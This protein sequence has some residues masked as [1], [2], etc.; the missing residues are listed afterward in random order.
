MKAVTFTA[1]GTGWWVACDVPAL[2]PGAEALVRAA[3]ARLS[4]FDSASSLSRLNA[5]R[6][7]TDPLLAA[8]V[9]AA[10]DL[11]DRTGGAFDPT[12]GARLAALGYDRDLA[13]IGRPAPAAA[14]HP[15]DLGVRVV[16]DEVRLDGAGALDL[17]GVAKGFTVDR[18]VAALRGWGARRVLVDGGGDLRGAGGAWPI[19]VGDGLAVWTDA[20]AVATSSTR[21]RRWRDQGDRPLH[22]VLD[23]RTGWPAA[24]PVRTAVVVA[25]DAATADGLATALLVDA[26]GVV[27]RLAGL[28]AHALL[29]VGAGG[30][31]MTPGA[32]VAATTAAELVAVAVAAGEA[33]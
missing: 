6:R 15:G 5:A 4:R 20:G 26:P 27:P 19:G 25:P 10:L 22:H 8:V 2:L 24:S 30:W 13:D 33:P 29:D 23:P 11:R 3:E 21:R 1:M 32:P 17:G 9:R 28:D 7:V 31:W 18:V 14:W 12:L 16:G